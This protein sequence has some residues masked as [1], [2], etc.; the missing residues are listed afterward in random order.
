MAETATVNLRI[1]VLGPLTVLLDDRPLDIAGGRQRAVLTALLSRPGVL[2]TDRLAALVVP[3][4]GGPDARNA[5]QTYVARLRRSGRRR[6]GRARDDGR[7]AGRRGG[8]TP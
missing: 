1:G 7:G 6:A 8:R 2:G 4:A 3:D 5:T